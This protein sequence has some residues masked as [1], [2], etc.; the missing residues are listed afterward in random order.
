MNATSILTCALLAGAPLVLWAGARAPLAPDE[1]SMPAAIASNAAQDGVSGE[2]PA[3]KPDAKSKDAIG[4]ELQ[5]AFAAQG[6]H[7]DLPRGLCTIP[8]TVLVRE[9]LLEYVL[10]NPH[11]QAHESM[12]LT[13][14]VPSS[15]NVALLALGVVPG[16]NAR[17]EKR[18]PPP[19]PE[20]IK[21][22][23]SG[24]EV[25]PPE[26]DGFYFYAAWKQDGETYLYRV[27]DL[28]LDRSNGQAMRRH[29]WVY[30]GSRMVRT[31]LDGADGPVDADGKNGT[32]NGAG[33][34]AEGAAKKSPPEEAYAADLEGNLVNVALFE[35]GNTLLTA[36]LPECLK[37]TI[38]MTN[39]W[40]VPPR[41]A[42][43]ELVFSRE[44]LTALPPEIEARL[45]NVPPAPSA[46]GG[47]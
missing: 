41:D 14:V 12:F 32:K 6:I 43:V 46:T 25:R 7:L 28:I 1:S 15:L 31:R 10:V 24:Y 30:L 40:I 37:Q 42:A 4:A 34:A 13:N 3:V 38:W 36:A 9:D 20:E 47:K 26:G 33:N 2:T 39:F 5:K 18:V 44:R 29:K 8:A 35:Q 27:E 23:E 16:R 11:G 45:P 21:N 17:W 22:G 19:T